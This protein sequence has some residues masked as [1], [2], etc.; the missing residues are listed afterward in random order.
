M[1]TKIADRLVARMPWLDGIAAG[2]KAAGEPIVG[3]EAPRPLKDALVGTWLGHPLHPAVVQFPIGFWTSSLALDLAGQAK[4]ADLTL[5]LGLASTPGAVL[6]GMA[7]WQDATTNEAPRRLGALHASLNGVATVLYGASLLQRRRGNRTS[8]MALAAAGYAIAN[9]SAWVGGDLA[10]DRAIGVDHTAFQQP[11]TDWVDVLDEGSL[12][13]GVPKRVRAKGY[14][15]MLLK[16]GRQINAIAATCPHLSG[17][18][19]KGAIDDDTVTCPWHGSV[20]CLSDGKLLHGPAT[21][22]VTVFDVR[23]EGERIFVRA[24]TPA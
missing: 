10:Y 5:A 11:P 7:Q 21:A 4:A 22:P 3:Q 1:R 13:E 15:V 12:V 24:G 2:L 16:R 20:F 17:P 8:G 19:D 9:A 18:L 23:V 14:P 6:T